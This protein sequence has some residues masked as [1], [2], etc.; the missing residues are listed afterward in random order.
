[1]NEFF[2]AGEEGYAK[3][4]E[5]MM[6]QND[7]NIK[8]HSTNVGKFKIE[9]CEGIVF[10]Y[11]IKSGSM[12]IISS[13]EGISSLNK[14]MIYIMGDVRSKLDSLSMKIKGSYS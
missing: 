4:I 7:V 2:A 9:F 11:D 1:L 14:Y 8:S 5:F 6:Q 12:S 10:S 3:R 13:R